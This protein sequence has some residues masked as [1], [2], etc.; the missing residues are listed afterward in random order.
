M[1]EVIKAKPVRQGGIDL[2]R[3]ISMFMVIVIHV[4]G[5]GG[6]LRNPLNTA[7]SP[8]W[9]IGSII[10]VFCVVAVNC[11]ALIS[12]Y[13]YVGKKTK[14][15]S[16]I[17][18]WIQAFFISVVAYAI[19][20]LLNEESFSLTMLIKQMLF[21]TFN[22]WWYFTAYFLLFFFIPIF[23]SAIEKCGK[24]LM[25]LLIIVFGIIFC[26]M[27]YASPHDVLGLINGYSFL[28]LAYLYLVGAYVKRY[29]FKI[30]IKGQPI[31]TGYY[32]L[33]Y[34]IFTV[35][36]LLVELVSSYFNGWASVPVQANYMYLFNFLASVSLLIFFANVKIKSSKT[37]LFF[38]ST[39]FGVYLL[40]TA[41]GMTDRFA[42]LLNYH[43]VIT[44]LAILGFAIIIYLGCTVLEYLR[45]LLFKA[46]KIPNAT[47]KLQNLLTE[48]YERL[49]TKYEEN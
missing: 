4:N 1:E 9:V 29:D 19:K 5:A 44:I 15:K 45:Q 17:N 7:W 48:K 12:G 8:V 37:L 21:I 39:T 20:V 2:F 33:L 22:K 26:G 32:F 36:H 10:Q 35:L 13:V 24:V 40:H 46:C 23:N 28:W 16:I 30:K 27:A 25:G 41:I 43:W 11:F 31:K 3:I 49:K 47:D 34:V 14:I 38:S 18:L 6:I 42:F